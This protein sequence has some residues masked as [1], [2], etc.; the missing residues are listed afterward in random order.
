M[1]RTAAAAVLQAHVCSAETRC[2]S[3]QGRRVAAQHSA[4]TLTLYLPVQPEEAL[5]RN[6]R[7]QPGARLPHEV[8]ARMCQ[9]WHRREAPRSEPALM[10][11]LGCSAPGLRP[12]MPID[13]SWQWL[14][15]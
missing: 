2:A 5:A 11:Q 1:P 9:V 8:M 4:A 15:A 14:R 12:D 3:V 6:D 7:R 13:S 10:V